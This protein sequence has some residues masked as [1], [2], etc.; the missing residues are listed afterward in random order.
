MWSGLRAIPNRHVAG[1]LT[2]TLIL[3]NIVLGVSVF[4]YGFDSALYNT[5]QAMTPFE[6]RFGSFNHKKKKYTIDPTHLALLNSFPLLTYAAGVFLAQQLGERF[7]RRIVLISMQFLCIAGLIVTYTAKD[8]GQILAGR[9]LVKA[10]IGMQQWLIPMLLAEIVSAAIRGFMVMFYIFEQELGALAC[11]IITNFTAKRLDDSS[12]RIPVAV[13]V[14]FPCFVLFFHWFIPESPRWLLRKGRFDDAVDSLQYLYGCSLEYSALEEAQLLKESL[15]EADNISKGSWRDLMRGSNRR[16]T[17][18]AIV[19]G[20]MSMLSGSPFTSSYGTVF[21]KQLGSIDPFTGNMIKKIVILCGPITSIL[22]IER[23]GRRNMYLI[24]GLMSCLA[25]ITMGGLGCQN[26]LGKKYKTGIVA[27]TIFFPYAR[28]VSFGAIG[29]IL[30][31]EVSHPRLRDKTAF[32]AWMTQNVFDFA[33]TFSLPYLL[34]APYANLQS[35]VGFIY[36]GFSMLGII[37]GIFCLPELRGRSLEEVDE[38]FEQRVPAW[39]TKSK[40][41]HTLLY[42]LFT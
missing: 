25:L 22:V 21:L 26:P 29:T 18:I 20:A 32:T 31:A 8:F 13:M 4:S 33:L 1:H 39:R 30:P 14:I 17:M 24:W 6:E 34:E 38:M 41:R 16:R 19:A 11:S 12:W 9:C 36:G 42:F 3:A 15:N 40:F 2:I 10:H 5:I 28:V 27:M 37:W 7:G 23:L 35:K